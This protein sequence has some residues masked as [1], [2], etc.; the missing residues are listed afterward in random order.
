MRG[1]GL[2]RH[3]RV[4]AAAARRGDA[5][6]RR[7]HRAL[8]GRSSPRPPGKSWPPRVSLPSDR[9]FAAYDSALATRASGPP[10]AE[11][12][13]FPWQQAMLDVLLE[14]PIA[15][16]T[17]SFS[18][19]PALA[20]LGVRTTTVLRFL[21]PSG[22][23]RAFQYVGDPGLVRLDPRWHQAALALRQARLRAHPRRHRP[24]AVRVLPRD[25]VPADP[26]ARGDR[27]VVHG[28]ALD[29]A[30]RLGVRF[31]ARRALVPAADRGADR[32]LDRVHGVREH[33]RRRRSS[34]GG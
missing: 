33:R 14:Y 24:P 3:R 10:L 9:S 17:S 23:E 25:S 8:R 5:L 1:V 4:D 20:H 32:A 7:L 21:P 34:G 31:R 11:Q 13:R 26:A 22:G 16:D 6:D 28:R 19:R 27:H 30:H 15:S 2:S 29:H 12:S 18:I